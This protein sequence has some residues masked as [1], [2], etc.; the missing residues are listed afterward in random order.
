MLAL[1]WGAI[2][3]RRAVST[4]MFLL[5]ALVSTGLSLAPWYL[6]RAVDTAATARIAAATPAERTVSATGTVSV[7]LAG[8]TVVQT[9]AAS[10]RR[11]LAL[12][13]TGQALGVDVGATVTAGERQLQMPLRYREALCDN[14]IVDGSCPQATGEVV[15]SGSS[16]ER[17][18]VHVGDRLEVRTGPGAPPRPLRLVGVYRP[19][20]PLSWYWTAA[21]DAAWTTFGT[22]AAAATTVRATFDALLSP[23]VFSRG[24]ELAAAVDRMRRVPLQ[25]DTAAVAL[26]DRI[27]TDRQV[28]ER[29]VLL[30]AAQLAVIGWLAM[31]VAA[32]YAAEARRFDAAQLAL[33]G[34]RR[35]RL[36]V[37]TS[38]QT[39]VPLAAGA[40]AGAVAGV[41]A[42]GPARL[43]IAAGVL[44]AALF[45][46][47]LADWR[48]TGLPVERLL[49][50]AAPRPPRLGTA[51]VEVC[52][53]GLAG[54]SVYQSLVARGAIGVQL[55]APGL[56]A[57]SAAILVGRLLVPA[58]TA[59][60][61]SA[62]V[63]GRVAAGFGA[64][65]LARRS[66]AYRMLPL[67]T[68]AGCLLAVAAQ[69]WAEAGHA[70]HERSA[71]EVGGER[72]LTVAGGDRVRL[73]NAV[74]AAD[75]GGRQAMAVV[76]GTGPGGEP[77]LAV[78]SP[79]LPYVLAGPAPLDTGRLRPPA[80]PPITFSGTGLTVTAAAPTGG[81]LPDAGAT[82]PTGP[83]VLL[84]TLVVT[85][86]GAPVTA[87]FTPIDGGSA[88][89]VANVPDCR[90]GCRLVSF[91]L[92]GGRAVE[93]R[94]LD[95]DGRTV[96]TPA[97]F[98]DPGRWRTGAGNI[99]A[100]ISMRAYDGRLALAAVTPGLSKL[101]ADGRLY[102]V[103]APVPLPA[104][105]AGRRPAADQRGTATIELS[106]GRAVP[107]EPI[108]AP[109]LPGIGARGVLVDL[110][111]ADR[112]AGGAPRAERQQVWLA[113]GAPADVV[114][115]LRA[116]GLTIAGED[117]LSAA[118]ARQD[119][120]G[121]AAAARYGLLMSVLGLL[122]AAIALLVIGAVQRRARGEEFVALRRQGVPA[123]ALRAAGRWAALAPIL[124]AALTAALAAAA[125]RAIAHPPIP[126]YIDAWPGPSGNPGVAVIA[127]L[128][129][130]AAVAALFAGCALAP[131]YRSGG[132]RP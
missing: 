44:A 117:S 18:G 109:L 43:P 51:V 102:V 79:R 95:A 90:S 113:P 70:R 52:V 76:A 28:L 89:A 38:G 85:A 91:E 88:T 112:I 24:G 23:P 31:A 57:A 77:M 47:A 69:Q 25:V 126:V 46:A 66:S 65:L 26:A 35:W 104:A 33:R 8:E 4:G 39:G 68:A 78:D 106:G 32:R 48:T 60:G 107:V 34:A 116:A 98:A 97:V 14:A 17:L 13:V 41:L 84:A 45:S 118:D 114:D 56:L 2:V 64:L 105:V 103:D 86:T 36:L 50:A 72:V 7:D 27:A 101:P 62:L 20:D 132:R 59:V 100:T 131:Q 1:I 58:A 61:R 99:A 3:A 53:L 83:P 12:P 29:G 37:A 81:D 11:A 125:A 74:R 82:P 71:V 123:A 9:F 6:A 129:A 122:A 120:S 87:R 21:D 128:A 92:A 40:L 19:A 119:R 16:A 108:A 111:Y 42:D 124:L 30:A 67:L 63:N 55:L 130:T 22:V 96:I 54:A 115:R 80:P 127:L 10:A 110:E 94:Q 73:L 49:R 93:L 75:P 15:L 5:A 121:P